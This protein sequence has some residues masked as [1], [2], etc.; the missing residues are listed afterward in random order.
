MNSSARHPAV[1]ERVAENLELKALEWI[2]YARDLPDEAAS[3]DEDRTPVTRP[4]VL[5]YAKAA[6]ETAA[7]IREHGYARYAATPRATG[8]KK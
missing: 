2:K 7:E 1:R 3:T 4:M 8:P 6:M 5:D